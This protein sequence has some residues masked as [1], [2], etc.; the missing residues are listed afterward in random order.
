MLM[1]SE[2]REANSHAPA[3]EEPVV[4]EETESKSGEDEFPF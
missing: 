2:R 4:S 3:G 1:L